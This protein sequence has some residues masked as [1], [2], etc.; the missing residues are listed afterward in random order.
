[1]GAFI[2]PNRH[3]ILKSSHPSPLSANRGFFGN[4]HFILANQYLKAH[5]EKEI[6]W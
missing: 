2:D 4:Q 6:D 5:G 3:L 1:K